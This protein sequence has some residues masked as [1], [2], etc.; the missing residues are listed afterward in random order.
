M[1]IAIL[2]V[3][4]LSFAIPVNL[5][6]QKDALRKYVDSGEY[7][8]DLWQS[9]RKAYSFLLHHDFDKKSAIIF[10]ID[11]TLL[12]NYQDMKKYDFGGNQN[13]YLKIE[14]NAN[15]KAIVATAK[16]FNEAKAK[17]LTIFLLTGR[18]VSGKKYTSENLAKVGLT[19]YKQIIMWQGDKPM[20]IK[21]FKS[22][23]RCDI[24]N[25]GYKIILNVGDQYSD[26]V[27]PCQAKI[28]VKLPN[29]FYILYANHVKQVVAPSSGR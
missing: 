26:L 1:K 28:N 16:I 17:G 23:A 10:D 15:G 2:L 24:K 8:Y 25:L 22:S 14:S 4:I 18:H 27:G 7:D 12:S 20:T 11:E 9:V 13:T 29:P 5:G 19:G 6:I 3:P 21:E